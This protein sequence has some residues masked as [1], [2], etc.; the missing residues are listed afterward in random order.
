[1]MI[2]PKKGAATNA[3]FALMLSGIASWSPTVN[4]EDDLASKVYDCSLPGLKDYFTPG[5]YEGVTANYL[6]FITEISSPNFPIRAAEFEA[7]T[8]GKIVFS[9]ANNIW[10]DP[11][12]DLGT[13]TRS[14]SE[15]YDGY[16]MSYSHFPEVSELGLAEHLND[17]IRKDN[18][19]LKWEDV[20]PKVQAMSQYR[21]NGASNIDFLMYDGDFFVPLVRLDLLEKYDIPM[22]NT[23][24]E[25]VEIAKFFHGKDINED[26]EGDFGLCHFPRTGAGYWDW[27]F[28][29]LVYSTWATTDQLQGTEGGFLFNAD[30]LEP[31]IGPGFEQ[32]VNTWKD[33]WEH[34][35]GACDEAASFESGR[36]AVGYAP[37]GCWKSVF[38]NGV[39]RKLNDTV[40]W[41]PNMKDGKYPKLDHTLLLWCL[42]LTL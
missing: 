12:S 26:G 36:C 39:G 38:L 33:I 16:F 20:M 9:D 21:K 13:K 19:R 31:N 27:W 34:G 41:E 11:I 23:W 28:S 37:P 29:E 15:I 1:M 40:V 32:A 4:G 5:Q 2:M 35:S 10:E 6:S 8:G 42:N 22:P 18:A 30:T 3:T 7:C 17:R 25:L 14:G 24:E